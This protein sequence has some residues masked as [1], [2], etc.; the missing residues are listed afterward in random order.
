MEV[1]CGKLRWLKFFNFVIQLKYLIAPNL[2]YG[3]TVL[4]L[5]FKMLFSGYLS[6]RVALHSSYFVPFVVDGSHENFTLKVMIINSPK[7]HVT[8]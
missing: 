2:S 5:N 8:L 3:V 7:L 4:L 6:I 1:S